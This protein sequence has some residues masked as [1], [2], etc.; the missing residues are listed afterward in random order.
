LSLDW[1]SKA[2]SVRRSGELGR[3]LCE[4]GEYG[5]GPRPRPKDCKTSLEPTIAIREHAG[6]P[7]KPLCRIGG[8]A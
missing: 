2:E 8:K 1:R 5:H 6:L 7:H 3:D 4:V